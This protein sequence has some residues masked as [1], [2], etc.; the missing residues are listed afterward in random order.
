MGSVEEETEREGTEDTHERAMIQAL[1]REA[2]G[3]ST[4]I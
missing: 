1:A 4:F 3:M 2:E